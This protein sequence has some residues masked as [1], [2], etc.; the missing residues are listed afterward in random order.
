MQFYVVQIIIS[1]GWFG[2]VINSAYFGSTEQS[3]INKF[4][5]S[6]FFYYEVT[7]SSFDNTISEFEY[8]TSC[9]IDMP[10]VISIIKWIFIITTTIKIVTITIII[11]INVIFIFLSFFIIVILGFVIAIAAIIVSVD[12]SEL[13]SKILSYGYKHYDC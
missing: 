1:N 10:Y 5:V 13:L 12:L 7:I 3:N 4:P 2:I 8:F 9:V 6:R 11:P